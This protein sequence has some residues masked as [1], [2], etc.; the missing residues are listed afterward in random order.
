MAHTIDDEES[1]AR[2]KIAALPPATRRFLANPVNVEHMQELA[3]ADIISETWN[4][5]WL[6]DLAD[7][8]ESDNA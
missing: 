6:T 5:A 1:E 3:D 8:I 4:L 2:D 7:D